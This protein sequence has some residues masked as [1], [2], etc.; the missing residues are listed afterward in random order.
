M[1]AFNVYTPVRE[2][3][4]TSTCM[5]VTAG[6]AVHKQGKGGGRPSPE[7]EE[8]MASAGGLKGSRPSRAGSSRND[9]TSKICSLEKKGF[10]EKNKI[11]KWFY[12]IYR[13]RGRKGEMQAPS[14]AEVVAGLEQAGEAGHSHTHTEDSHDSFYVGPT[15]VLLE[16]NS[17]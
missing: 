9:L 13:L 5:T 10:R 8:E 3:D 6:K 4:K 17:T 11:R 12:F 15:P 7:E 16:P 1:R 14:P 2:E